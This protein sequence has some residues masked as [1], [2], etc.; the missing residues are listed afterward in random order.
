MPISPALRRAEEA[1]ALPVAGIT[2]LQGLRKGAC[3]AGQKVLVIGAGGGIGSFAVQ[4]AQAFGASVD[5]VCSARHAAFVRA[6]GAERVTDYREEDYT[7]GGGRYDLIFDLAG[8][9]SFS[10]QRRV[11]APEGVV[12]LGGIA[13]GKTRLGWMLRWAVRCLGGLLVARFSTQ[14]LAFVSAKLHKDDLAE[15]AA[16][17]EAGKIK[18]AIGAR[19]ALADAGAALA[20]VAEGHAEGKVVIVP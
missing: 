13:G 16:L 17:A 12:I 7:R 9:R 18:P 11:L 3:R 6:L 15:L 2:A 1:A 20:H 14:R 19:Y 5:G 4:I 8:T 10:A